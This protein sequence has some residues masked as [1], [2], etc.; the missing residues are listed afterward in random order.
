MLKIGVIPIGEVED[1]FFIT[2]FLRVLVSTVSLDVS[3]RL[4][5]DLNNG[6]QLTDMDIQLLY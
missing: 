6:R 1:G 2:Q 5:Q 4:I 3:N